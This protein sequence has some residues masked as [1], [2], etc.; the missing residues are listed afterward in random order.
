MPQTPGVERGYAPSTPLRVNTGDEE[1]HPQDFRSERG[2]HEDQ[3]APQAPQPRRS[4]RA[5]MGQTTRFADSY[6][7]QEYDAMTNSLS[8]TLWGILD[9]G[10]HS[11]SGG[12]FQTP[13][14][15][16]E[17]VGADGCLMA[18]PLPRTHWDKSAWWTT[19]GWT[20]IQH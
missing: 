8:S 16:G 5:N 10:V 19:Q 20:W 13:L 14:I 18:L 6:T 9:T 7:G 4:G 17:I 2:G 12:E 11:P 3:V 15:I 1:R